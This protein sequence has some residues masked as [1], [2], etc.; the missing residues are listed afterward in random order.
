M[1]KSILQKLHEDKEARETFH[2][3]LRCLANLSTP[4]T[5]QTEEETEVT[6]LEFTT[7]LDAVIDLKRRD[8][9]EPDVKIGHWCCMESEKDVEGMDSWPVYWLTLSFR[10]LPPDDGMPK[11]VLPHL[12]S[13]ELELSIWASGKDD[14]TILKGIESWVK[15]HFP[16]WAIERL[17]C[18]RR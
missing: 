1:E 4:T 13:K 15:V 2:R 11:V 3:F 17:K 7:I 14:N 8:T 5:G 6:E 12:E 9:Q 16:I 18:V 10:L